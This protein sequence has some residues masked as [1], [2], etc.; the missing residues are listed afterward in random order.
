M[1]RALKNFFSRPDDK[2]G[3]A[4]RNQDRRSATKRARTVGGHLT[5][6]R[7][8][9]GPNHTLIFETKDSQTRAYIWDANAGQ[10]NQNNQSSKAAFQNDSFASEEEYDKSVASVIARIKSGE[11]R[12]IE[13]D[14]E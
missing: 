3:T 2:R 7:L 5:D 13:P 11:V 9:L 4:R 8:D 14:S 1:A 10:F 12:P 6:M